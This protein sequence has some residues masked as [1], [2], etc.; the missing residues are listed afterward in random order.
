M[1]D[2]QTTEAATTT[3]ADVEQQEQPTA[4]GELP[5]D[6]PLV[7]TLAAQKAAIKELKSKASRLDALEEAQKTDAEKF[8][9]RISKA[10]AE[11]ASV[12]SKVALA[13]REHL[14]GLHEIDPDDAE[15]FLTGN[16]PEL[17]LKQVTRLIG[18]SDKR[19]AKKNYVPREGN[20]PSNNQQADDARAFA[21]D[22][23]GRS[24]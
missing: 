22:F 24:S 20:A 3:E 4:N 14:V 1:S 13:L 23:F 18:Q 6:H 7:K 15:L 11:A 16:T 17:L 21:R 2:Q 8:A 9:D 12:P 5:A 19:Q 10:E